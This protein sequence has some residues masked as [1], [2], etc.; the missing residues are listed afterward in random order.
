MIS[1]G[2]SRA[3]EACSRNSSRLVASR[4]A[5]VATARTAVRSSLRKTCAIPF[6]RWQTNCMVSGAMLPEALK[7]AD[8]LR[9]DGVFASVL[10]CV[11]P[12]LVFRAWSSWAGRGGPPVVTVLDGHP[13]ALAWVGAM[14]GVRGEALGV[15]GFGQWGTPADLYREFGI[16]A[17]AISLASFRVLGD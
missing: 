6:R 5:L 15:T 8:D 7:A 11:S 3:R 10:S 16:D 12:D 9:L 17:E 14:L 2:A 1:I 13:S 4:T